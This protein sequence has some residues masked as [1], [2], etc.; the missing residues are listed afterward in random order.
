MLGFVPNN[1]NTT[2][3]LM[4]WEGLLHSLRGAKLYNK[5]CKKI[6]VS[7]QFPFEFKVGRVIL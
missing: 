2:E 7:S 3:K 6:I 5:T 4:K 1:I